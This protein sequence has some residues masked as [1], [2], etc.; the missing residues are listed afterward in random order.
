LSY[1]CLGMMEENS[2][3]ASDYESNPHAFVGYHQDVN[4]EYENI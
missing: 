2:N 4:M 1:L 3:N